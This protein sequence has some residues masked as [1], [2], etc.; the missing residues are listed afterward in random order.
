MQADLGRLDTD[1]LH[2]TRIH[3]FERAAVDRPDRT[4]EQA[5]GGKSR[6]MGEAAGRTGTC[7]EQSEKGGDRGNKGNTEVLLVPAM[8]LGQAHQAGQ[9]DGEARRT[10][11]P[12]S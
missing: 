11:I 8:P 9:L 7:T 1:I 12:A 2:H 4:A 10:R 3:G 5:T 6:D